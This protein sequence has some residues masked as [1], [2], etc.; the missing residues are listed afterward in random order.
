M[1]IILAN[2]RGF[3]AGVDTAIRIVEAAITKYGTPVFVR[4]EI[5]HNQSVVNSLKEQGAI[6]V[7]DVKEVPD[8]SVIIFS[9]HGAGIEVY[10]EAK[11]KNLTIL[12]A[13]CP[14]VKKIHNNIIK[15]S[16]E[17]A[18]IILIGHNGH[19]EVEGHLGQIKEKIY[20]I[21]RPEDIRNLPF[22]KNEKLAY[23]TQTTLSRLESK[24]IISELKNK[25]PNI[26]GPKDGDLCYATTNRQ[27]AIM[28]LA[29][30]I[31]LLLVVGS[32]NSSNSNRLKELGE[33]LNIRSYLIDEPQNIDFSWFVNVE[34]IGITSGASAPEYLVQE[35]ISKISDEFIIDEVEEIST[36]EE[37]V[38]FPMPEMLK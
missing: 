34:T 10:K 12:D 29:G 24:S 6:F 37:K 9:A 27:K 4:N 22:A 14:L 2:P 18:K 19:P 5:V 21:N 3:C 13:S 20:L 35:L 36:I 15:Y 17:G 30:K 33:S 28:N 32:P 26:L 16:T 7:K 23:I 1:K 25:Y 38:R 11:Q 31:D 8:S